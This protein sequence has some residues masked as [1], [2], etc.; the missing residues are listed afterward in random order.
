MIRPVN[1]GKVAVQYR[2]ASIQSGGTVVGLD[3]SNPGY[4]I[5]VSSNA[6]IPY[7]LLGQDVVD[8]MYEVWKLDS[9]TQRARVSGSVGVYYEGGQFILCSGVGYAG[10][11]G[12]GALLYPCVASGST[13]YGWLTTSAVSGMSAVA[14][15]ETS[16]TAASGN[17][18]QIRMLV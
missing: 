3:S 10:T 2:C 6:Q 4:V 17:N 14:M 12:I 8:T 18:L 7:G 16:G 15:A 11:V 13:P 9:E 1:Q 5:P